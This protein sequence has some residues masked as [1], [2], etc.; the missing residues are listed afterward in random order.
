MPIIKSLIGYSPEK[1]FSLEVDTEKM[2]QQVLMDTTQ[3]LD[4]QN[5]IEYRQLQTQ[6][7]LQSIN[8]GYN[9]AAY[10]PKLSGFINYSWNFLND[11][12]GNLYNQSYPGSI[13]GLRLNIPIFQGTIA[14]TAN[15]E[16]TITGKKN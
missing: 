15:Q 8:T 10:L 3:M 13:V 12:F 6:K 11:D 16:I 5:R 4:Y 9:K 2:E 1:D 7:Q 14:Y